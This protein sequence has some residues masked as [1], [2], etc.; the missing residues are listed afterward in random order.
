ML[1]LNCCMC[2]H[3]VTKVWATSR[4][5]ETLTF[6]H[7]SSNVFYPC[8]S[9]FPSIHAVTR[10]ATFW[11]N[12]FF[13]VIPNFLRFSSRPLC[14]VHKAPVTMGITLSSTFH[15]LVI[16]LARFDFTE[17][18]LAP[19]LFR[20]LLCLR[21]LQCLLRVPCC[22]LCLQLQCL[23]VGVQLCSRFG[24]S[25]P[26]E[27]WHFPCLS[28]AQLCAGTNVVNTVQCTC[29]RDSSAQLQQ[30][31]SCLLLY[32]SWASLL[33]SLAMCAIVYSL[34]LHILHV[35][36]SSCF[37]ILTFIAIVY[38][39]WSCAAMRNPS[40]SFFKLLAVNHG[41]FF[42]VCFLDRLS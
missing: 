40:I 6:C 11:I 37:S 26:T 33:L 9:T 4:S 23:V 28:L 15:S 39:A 32:S 41:Q 7:F 2:V 35:S 13:I 3:C 20:W 1:I 30:L 18:F 5:L 19:Y 16:S 8:S 24:Y 22:S 42:G 14:I 34:V 12:S 38:R 17:P 36:S 25:R 29:Y 27:F 21:A 31:L 10:S